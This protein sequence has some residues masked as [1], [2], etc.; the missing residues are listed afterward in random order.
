MNKNGFI[1][2]FTIS[3]LVVFSIYSISIIETRT[4]S[5]NINK[6]KYLHLQANIHLL[7][8]KNKILNNID[9]EDIS[10]SDDRFSLEIVENIDINNS[11][12]NVSIETLD[13]T[14]IRLSEL[15]IK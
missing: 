8:I 15:I 6:L 2:V 11:Y 1:L 10:L 14:H 5:S 13:D 7:K 3:L 12:Y 9:I 4:I